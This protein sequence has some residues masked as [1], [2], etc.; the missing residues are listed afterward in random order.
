M[1]L[2]NDYDKKHN[3]I[4]LFEKQFNLFTSYIQIDN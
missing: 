2:R 1:L 4:F 3:K